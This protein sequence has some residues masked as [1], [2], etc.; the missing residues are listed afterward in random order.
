MTTQKGLLQRVKLSRKRVAALEAEVRRL[1][2]K[3]PPP[4]DP[5]L[6]IEQ[7]LHSNNENIDT[8]QLEGEIDAQ[9][10]KEIT[11]NPALQTAFHTL[12][13]SQSDEYWTSDSH[14]VSVISVIGHSF[15]CRVELTKKDETVVKL[16]IRDLDTP[17]LKAYVLKCCQTRDIVGLFGGLARYDQLS[18]ARF[19]L[20]ERLQKLESCTS[21]ASYSESRAVFKSRHVTLYLEWRIVENN[22]ENEQDGEDLIS[23]VTMKAWGSREYVSRDEKNVLTRLPKVFDKLVKL[24]GLYKASE[25]L[26]RSLTMS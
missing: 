5:Q 22:D 10:T 3:I 9:L 20:F 21:K 23:K 15:Q 25:V 16:A 8:R 11:S 18:I 12:E 1:E 17:G 13:L 4:N 6:L 24:K 14:F 19:A 2:E 7:L 26:V